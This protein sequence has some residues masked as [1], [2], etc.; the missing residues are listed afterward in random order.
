ME[1]KDRRLLYSVPIFLSKEQLKDILRGK[2]IEI[3]RKGNVLKIALKGYNPEV[4]R[5]K[6]QIKMLQERLKKVKENKNGKVG[7]KASK[8]LA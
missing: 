1:G 7:R 4:S 5:I 8:R 6:A 3:S 2:M